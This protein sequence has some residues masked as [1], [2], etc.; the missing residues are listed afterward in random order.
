LPVWRGS[1]LFLE[2]STLR[3]EFPMTDSRLYRAVAR[4]TGEDRQTI[5]RLGFVVLTRGPV[6]QDRQPLAIDWDED[7]PSP[8]CHIN[9]RPRR[10][11]SHF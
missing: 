2:T 5:A 1:F 8:P 7:H 10:A 11:R 4:A 3:K 6:E 9:R